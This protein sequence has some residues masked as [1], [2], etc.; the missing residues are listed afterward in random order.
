MMRPLLRTIACVCLLLVATGARAGAVAAAHGERGMVVTANPIATDAAVD[1]MRNGGNAVDAAVAAALMLGVV[2]GHNSGVGGGC[3]M[4][5]RR[6]D[7]TILAI[8]GRETAPAAV[9]PDTFLR[10]DG[11]ADPSRSQTG[12]LA[13]GVPGCL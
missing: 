4:L 6:A 3:F 12:P 1:V 7:G 11:A 10:P 5:V 9:R 8:D 13:S 2:D